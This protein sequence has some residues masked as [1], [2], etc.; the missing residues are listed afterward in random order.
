MDDIF[1]P[2]SDEEFGLV[3]EEIGRQDYTLVMQHSVDYIY[4]YTFIL[5]TALTLRVSVPWTMNL[6]GMYY[7]QDMSVSSCWR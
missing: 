7:N 3:E 5:H 1:F 6:K 4:I 2:G